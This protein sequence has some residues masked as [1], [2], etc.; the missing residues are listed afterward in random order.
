MSQE[1]ATVNTSKCSSTATH[2][3]S[4]LMLA[5]VQSKDSVRSS[6]F[7]DGSLVKSRYKQEIK[8]FTF[9]HSADMFIR[10][11]LQGIYL[12]EYIP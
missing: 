2:T 8:T 11:H 3:P 1:D 7:V 4:G 6:S 12:S 5:E 10:S 9:K